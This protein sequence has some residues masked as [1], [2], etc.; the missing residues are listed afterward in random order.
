MTRWARL[1]LT[2]LALACAGA[3]DERRSSYL[4]TSPSIRRMQDDDASNPGMLWVARGETLWTSPGK[5]DGKTCG[6]CHGAAEQSMS[7]VAARHPTMDSRTNRPLTLDAQIRRCRSE[8]MGLDDPGPDGE[9]VL[10]LGAYFGR[11]SRGLPIMAPDGEAERRWTARG[12]AI[13]ETRIGQLN[14]SCANCHDRLAGQRL[15][16]SAIPQAHPTGYPQYRLEWQAM[17]SLTRRIRNCTTGVRAEA[18]GP[19]SDEL[20]ALAMFLY[21][22]ARGMPLEAPAVR[23]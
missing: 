6:S 1:F 9:D 5:T 19:D 20:G 14:L 12:R 22:R 13:F 3:G 4:D 17:G 2:S 10:A 11:L 15:A 18:F 7:G 23:P 8:R 16:G 21:Q